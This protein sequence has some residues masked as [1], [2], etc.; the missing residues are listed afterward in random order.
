MTVVVCGVVIVAGLR[1]AVRWGTVGPAGPGTGREGRD[2]GAQSG[3]QVEI[4]ARREDLGG[5][6]GGDEVLEGK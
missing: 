2:Q 3:N 5:R 6:D 4:Q 1:V